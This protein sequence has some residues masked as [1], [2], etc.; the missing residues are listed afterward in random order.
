MVVSICLFALNLFILS[1]YVFFFVL[2]ST[3]VR[4]R[5]FL[6]GILQIFLR[7]KTG[8]YLLIQQLL[9]GLRDDGVFL[10]GTRR[11]V[12]LVGRFSVLL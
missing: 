1:F 9:C 10:E 12:S 5:K 7:S 11:H 8:E 2:S 3:L 4:E 6:T